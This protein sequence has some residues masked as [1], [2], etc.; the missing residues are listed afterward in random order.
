MSLNQTCFPAGGLLTPGQSAKPNE[1]Q[2]RQPEASEL[3]PSAVH[4]RSALTHKNAVMGM[5][6]CLAMISPAD[7]TTIEALV[8]SVKSPANSSVQLGA[9]YALGMIG[10][11]AA[12]LGAPLLISFLRANEPLAGQAFRSLCAMNEAA[13]PAIG[14]AIKQD[15]AT[16][17][18]NRLQRL[19]VPIFKHSPKSPGL[20]KVL[21]E[22]AETCLTDGSGV[23]P[24]KAG[25]ALLSHVL[26]R[27]RCPN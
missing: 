19:L 9:V 24:L 13:L 1:K 16:I 23:G 15:G 18:Y 26:T 10:A 20:I 27:P 12:E 21:K 22:I 8:Q 5:A 25:L 7:S 17:D 14:D 11:P 4:L 3:R 6:E 2:P